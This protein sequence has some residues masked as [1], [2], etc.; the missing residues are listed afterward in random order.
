MRVRPLAIGGHVPDIVVTCFEG[1]TCGLPGFLVVQRLFIADG[2]KNPALFFLSLQCA[3]VHQIVHLVLIVSRTFRSQRITWIRRLSEKRK[4]II[5]DAYIFSRKVN[6]MDAVGNANA[7]VKS[8]K[9]QFGRN[10]HIDGHEGSPSR[11]NRPRRMFLST[12]KERKVE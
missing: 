2:F 7:A 11:L 3:K 12:Y 5:C 1:F 8:R 6:G 9:H 10:A 4:S